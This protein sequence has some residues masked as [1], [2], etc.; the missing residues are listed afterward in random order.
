MFS[1]EPISCAVSVI[2]HHFM[3]VINKIENVS[4]TRLLGAF[5]YPLLSCKRDNVFCVYFIAT[6][7]AVNNKGTMKVFPRKATMSFLCIF[8]LHMSV[9]I[10][11]T[12]FKTFRNAFDYINVLGSSSKVPDI[13]V[14][15]EPNLDLKKQILMKVA[16][17]KFDGNPSTVI[18]YDTCGRTDTHEE[19]NRPLFF[20]DYANARKMRDD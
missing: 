19:C 4:T 6:F 10:A 2:L 20:C 5:V 15:F 9:S 7:F 1:T 14:R 18:R 8:I 16:N 3:T 13:I 11:Q 17:I 12:E